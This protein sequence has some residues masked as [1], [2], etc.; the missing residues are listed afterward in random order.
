MKRYLLKTLGLTCITGASVFAPEAEHSSALYNEESE[1]LEGIVNRYYQKSSGW[2]SKIEAAW[3]WE[4]FRAKR[5][6]KLDGAVIR[7][8]TIKDS[9]I[10]ESQE[11]MKSFDF[12][13]RLALD[14]G[15]LNIPRSADPFP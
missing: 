5:A 3:L 8:I 10:S 9:S 12:V 4:I 15:L 1:Q 13:Y 11:D 14:K 7:K 2:K 6:Y